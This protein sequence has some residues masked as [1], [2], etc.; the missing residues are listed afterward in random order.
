MTQQK[1]RKEGIIFLSTKISCIAFSV[2]TF[3]VYFIEFIHIHKFYFDLILQ[4][5]Q[6]F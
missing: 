6:L 4:K 1:E 5:S 2:R 3:I